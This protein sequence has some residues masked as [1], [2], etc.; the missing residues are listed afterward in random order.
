[1]PNNFFGFTHL[2]LINSKPPSMWRKI[3]EEPAWRRVA[4]PP[5]LVKRAYYYNL[6]AYEPSTIRDSRSW[7][8]ETIDGPGSKSFLGLT[9]H[10]YATELR[11]SCRKARS[12]SRLEQSLERESTNQ[13]LVLQL[14]QA[15]LTYSST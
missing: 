10:R 8:R 5:F 12:F 3:A 2:L 13:R 11:S 14:R 6:V 4:R 9:L 7:R 1:M 15:L